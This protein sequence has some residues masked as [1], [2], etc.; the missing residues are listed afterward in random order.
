MPGRAFPE[1]AVQG[2]PNTH[3][4]LETLPEVGPHVAQAGAMGA[5]RTRFHGAASV[6]VCA[7]G[8]GRGPTGLKYRSDP[9]KRS[10]SSRGPRGRG[11]TWSWGEGGER[12]GLRWSL[13][14]GGGGTTE[15][16]GSGVSPQRTPRASPASVQTGGGR[17]GG[18]VTARSA[19]G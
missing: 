5:R 7:G 19:T 1:E 16:E 2:P 11:M 15:E 9:W 13:A 8:D 3:P 6:R 17:R 12:R 14:R 18:A 4:G 10:W